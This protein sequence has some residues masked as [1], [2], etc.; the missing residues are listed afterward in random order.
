MS[1]LT[2]EQIRSLEQV[3]QRLL[4]LNA[5]LGALRTDLAGQ[6]PSW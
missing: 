6:L 4:S 3:R 5:S 2:A 1:D